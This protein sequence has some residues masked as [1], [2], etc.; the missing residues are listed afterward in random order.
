[1][2]ILVAGTITNLILSTSQLTNYLCACVF[3]WWQK[4]TQ[5]TLLE[6]FETPFLTLLPPLD[7]VINVLYCK[8]GCSFSQNIFKIIFIFIFMFIIIISKSRTEFKLI[9]FPSWYY[10]THMYMH[11]IYMCM[12]THLNFPLKEQKKQKKKGMKYRE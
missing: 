8:L 10:S 6:R 11:C 5:R 1:M 7:L 9:I 3:V 4:H 2:G 12:C